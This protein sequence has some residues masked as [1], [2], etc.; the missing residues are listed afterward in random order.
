MALFIFQ[1]TDFNLRAELA[2]VLVFWEVGVTAL[3]PIIISIP[4]V[5]SYLAVDR[6]ALGPL[7]SKVGRRHGL[8]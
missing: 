7:L 2:L 8:V 3:I 6:L 5:D 1:N 4:R